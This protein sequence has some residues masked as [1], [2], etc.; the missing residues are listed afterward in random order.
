MLGDVSRGAVASTLREIRGLLPLAKEGL[1]DD[2]RPPF[3]P[4]PP[5]HQTPAF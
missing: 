3:L 5:H 4:L 1:L 2:V